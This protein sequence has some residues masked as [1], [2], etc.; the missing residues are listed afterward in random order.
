MIAIRAFT[1]ETDLCS[2]FITALNADDWTAYAETGGWD[3]LLVRKVDG[4][5]IGVQ[6]K[7]R[8]TPEVITQCLDSSAWR[9][10]KAGPDCRA[11]LVPAKGVQHHLGVICDYI[12]VTVIQVESPHRDGADGRVAF[13]PQLP[14]FRGHENGDWIEI[15]PAKRIKL[16]EYVPDVPAGASAP[17]QLTDWK[18]KAIKIAITLQKRGRLTRKDFAHLMIDHRLWIA[19]ERS[20][21]VVSDGVFMAGTKMPNF[22]KM[23]PKVYAEIA[24]N[25]DAWIFKEPPPQLRQTSLL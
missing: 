6:A 3:I 4:F 18:I 14:K 15:A 9:V 1:S 12:G 24:A 2:R 22:K 10:D 19:P 23:H 7:L 17:L 16:P 5:Q 8:F 25:A 21:L 11:V 20:W 13:R